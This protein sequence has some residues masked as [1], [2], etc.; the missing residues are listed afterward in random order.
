[1]KQLEYE[2]LTARAEEHL[3][4]TKGVHTVLADWEK[5][6]AE[7]DDVVPTATVALTVLTGHATDL[8][9][10]RLALAVALHDRGVTY[11]TIGH[12]LGVSAMSAQRWITSYREQRSKQ[13]QPQTET[14]PLDA[15]A[16]DAD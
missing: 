5:F 3:H 16:K 11:K 7:G 2:A 9:K 14:L 8:E 12:A 6:L 13:Q 15:T 1:M 4:Q 10:A